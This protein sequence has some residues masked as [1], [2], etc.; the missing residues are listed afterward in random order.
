MKKLKIALAIL[1]PWWVIVRQKR[2]INTLQNSVKH[3]SGILENPRIVGMEVANQQ[4]EIGL[5]GPLV[6]YM[7]GM[8]RGL[9]EACG[10]D[11]YLELQLTSPNGERFAVIV[12]KPG[13][14]KTLHELRAAAEAE[15]AALRAEKRLADI[16]DALYRYYDAQKEPPEEWLAERKEILEY[17]RSLDDHD[18][19]DDQG[20]QPYA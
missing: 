3:L 20:D 5:K 8:M 18:S 16:E 17:L 19:D 4:L 7:E 1:C 13:S 9:V 12:T 15:V 2:L 6:K 11:N 14:G 10:G